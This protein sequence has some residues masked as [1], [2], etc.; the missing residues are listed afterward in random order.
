MGKIR[1]I[2]NGNNNKTLNKINFNGC[3][4]Y[5]NSIVTLRLYLKGEEARVVAS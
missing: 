1:T 2:G 4:R 5:I 3:F